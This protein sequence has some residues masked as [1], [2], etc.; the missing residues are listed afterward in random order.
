MSL[1][2]LY[3][4]MTSE[5]KGL[6]KLASDEQDAFGRIVA[7]GFLAKSEEMSKEA[8]SPAKFKQAIGSRAQ[9]IRKLE[10]MGLRGQATKLKQHTKKQLGRIRG[11]KAPLLRDRLSS[12]KEELLERVKQLKSEGRFEEARKIKELA[13]LKGA[14]VSG[15]N[16]MTSKAYRTSPSPATKDTARQAQSDLADYLGIG[17][18]AAAGGGLLGYMAGQEGKKDE[19]D[20]Y[21][22]YY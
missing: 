21:G 5:P 15:Y 22:G 4:R 13:G 9:L 11:E 1:Q 7:R 10:S 6:E 3:E 19:V 20:R 16:K 2:K 17:A 8:I 12:K 18:G 14:Q